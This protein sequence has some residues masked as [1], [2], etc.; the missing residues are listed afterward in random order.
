MKKNLH[1]FSMITPKIKALTILILVMTTLVMMNHTVM[2][3]LPEA[4]WNV[5]QGNPIKALNYFK[6]SKKLIINL[7]LKKLSKKKKMKRLN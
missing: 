3:E 2:V 1:F 4:S 6:M 5:V 7:Q